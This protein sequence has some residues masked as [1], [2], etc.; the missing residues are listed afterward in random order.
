MTDFAY[1]LPA[2]IDT[3]AEHGWVV[4][5]DFLSSAEVAALRSE[6]ERRHTAGEFHRAG[7]GRANEQHVRDDIRTD[8]VRWL[9]PLDRLPAELPYWTCIAA[10]Q[11]ALNRELYLGLR[12]G[13]F[14][15]AH[16][17]AGG[18]YQRHRDRF[19][20]N[21]A[22]VISCVFYLNEN[23]QDSEGGHLRLWLDA[24]G[25][26]EYRDVAPQAGRLVLFTSERF[27]HAVQPASR[28][29]WSITGWLRR[30]EI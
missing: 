21:T 6:G 30:A 17:P 18:F 4:V 22:R 29:R 8:D 27:W 2:I 12:D 25:Q 13:E 15:Y 3:L 19:R 14:H 9:D 5:D 16:Y 28:P 7:V 20:D 26:G 24:E 11:A 10:L 23:W 1:R